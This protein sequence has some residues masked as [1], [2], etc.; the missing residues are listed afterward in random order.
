ML[1][2]SIKLHN[3]RQFKDESINFAN[4]DDGKNVTI[5]IGENGTGKTTFAQEMATKSGAAYIS[6]DEVRYVVTKSRKIDMEKEK[7]VLEAFCK[8]IIRNLEYKDL[9]FADA[10]HTSPRSRFAFY[11]EIRNTAKEQNL[12]PDNIDI[13]PIVMEAPFELCLERN[14]ARSKEFQAPEEDRMNYYAKCN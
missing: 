1:L 8:E 3:F 13:I 6:R 11:H 2:E 5:I 9:A 12:D 4:G 14:A 10:T 7:Y